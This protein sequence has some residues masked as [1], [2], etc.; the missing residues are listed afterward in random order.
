M[1]GGVKYGDIALGVECAL[2]AFTRPARRLDRAR[3]YFTWLM[4]ALRR[5]A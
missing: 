1:T 3:R 5:W 4:A 2:P